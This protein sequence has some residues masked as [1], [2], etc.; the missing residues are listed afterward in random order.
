MH[1]PGINKVIATCVYEDI[2][3]IAVTV[4]GVLRRAEQGPSFRRSPDLPVSER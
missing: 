3:V 1:N 4:V 2:R